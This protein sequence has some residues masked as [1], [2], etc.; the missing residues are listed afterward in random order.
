M[1][2]YG[3]FRQ[4]YCVRYGG[5]Q[6]LLKRWMKPFLAGISRFSRFEPRSGGVSVALLHRLLCSMLELSANPAS[7]MEIRKF[8]TRNAA[9]ATQSLFIFAK[10]F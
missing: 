5:I 1:S 9:G 3:A 2:E 7:A 8:E 6:R 4:D 10:A